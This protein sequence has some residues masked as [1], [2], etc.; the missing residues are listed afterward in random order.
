MSR[1]LARTSSVAAILALSLL[2]TGCGG[3]T[4]FT[5]PEADVSEVKVVGVLPFENLS[6]DKMAGEKV[7]RIFITELL[8][9]GKFD[10]LEPGVVAR[11]LRNEKMDPF[12]IGVDETKKLGKVL[13][14]QGLFTGSV[15]EYDEG[16]GAASSGGSVTIHLR[17]L[18]TASGKTIWSASRTDNG[19][20]VSARLFAMGAK[21]G[22][23]VAES[24]IRDELKT[25]TR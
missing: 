20:N 19:A 2:G 21:T 8:A 9:T 12:A 15:V 10:V 3:P 4:T 14:A 25:L 7:Q 5:H 6:S 11:A 23:S 16:R 17:L 13:N 18:D 24:L 1:T 22:V